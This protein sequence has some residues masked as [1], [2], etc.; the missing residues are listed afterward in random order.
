MFWKIYFWVMLLLYAIY[1]AAA[2]WFPEEMELE[3]VDY[4]D[5]V[6]AML[7]LVGVFGFAFKE[8]IGDTHKNIAVLLSLI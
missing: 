6:F 7:A 3:V 1:V 4:I 8:E 5:F 2:I